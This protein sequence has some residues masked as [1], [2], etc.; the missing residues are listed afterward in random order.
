MTDSVLN[1]NDVAVVIII[2]AIYCHQ[3]LVYACTCKFTHAAAGS[4]QK[5]R[6]ASLY[7]VC[8]FLTLIRCSMVTCL[9]C[10]YYSAAV[11]PASVN[12]LRTATANA[13]DAVTLS[14]TSPRSD[15]QLFYRVVL[16]SQW[17]TAN[18][19][20]NFTTLVSWQRVRYHFTSLYFNGRSGWQPMT[21]KHKMY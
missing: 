21:N 13:S 10:E 9:C 3:P 19:V 1:D 2:I 16:T 4:R 18:L 20:W 7:C 8:L 14:W 6:R 15:R 5:A 12:G 17:D 11:K